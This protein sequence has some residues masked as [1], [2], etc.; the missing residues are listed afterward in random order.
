MVLALAL[1]LALAQARALA[2][3][4]ARAQAWALAL[5]LSTVLSRLIASFGGSMRSP[6]IM[7]GT[8]GCVTAAR[9][10]AAR[11]FS[12]ATELVRGA[13]WVGTKGEG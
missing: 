13:P 10:T 7:R 1:T 12:S 2:L 11:P 3:A 9:A 6:S 5:A 8:S 4:R